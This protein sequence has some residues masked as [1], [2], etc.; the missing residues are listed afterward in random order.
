M[1]HTLDIEFGY[2]NKTTLKSSYFTAPF[3]VIS[4]FYKDDMAILVVMSSSAGIM[5]GDNQHIN[6]TVGDKCYAQVTSQSYEKIHK[7]YSE[8]ATRETTINVGAGAKFI[9]NPLP[10]IPFAHSSFKATTNINLHA[11]AKLAYIETI[12]AGRIHHNEKFMYNYYESRLDIHV[13]NTV[14][15]IDNTYFDPIM[16]DMNSFGMYEG[17]TH[18]LN[19]VLINWDTTVDIVREQLGKFDDVMS[20]ASLTKFG[21][22]VVK[23]LANSG[24]LLEEIVAQ[25]LT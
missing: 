1:E 18:L 21:D 15:Y 14:V 2:T 23:V 4:P 3:K 22:I 16:F 6:I 5:E 20:G 7:M 13:N 10:T 9:Y 25:I 12:S 8:N 17:Y 11:T 24:Q 19:V